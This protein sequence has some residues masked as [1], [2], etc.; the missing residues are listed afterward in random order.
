MG[1]YKTSCILDCK[2][3][4][5]IVVASHRMLIHMTMACSSRHAMGLYTCAGCEILPWP[6][7]K[8]AM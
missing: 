2:V 1:R 8:T 6:L 7:W 4:N 3:R 5:V